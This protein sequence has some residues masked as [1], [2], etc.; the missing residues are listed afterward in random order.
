MGDV[1]ARR[2]FSFFFLWSYLCASRKLYVDYAV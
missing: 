2:K 1:Y